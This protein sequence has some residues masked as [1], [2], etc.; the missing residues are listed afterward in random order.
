MSYLSVHIKH[1]CHLSSKEPAVV[2]DF[3]WVGLFLNWMSIALLGT[4]L[5]VLP[6][7]SNIAV[8][9]RTFDGAN[10]SYVGIVATLLILAT[11]VG[12]VV[13]LKALHKQ[14]GKADA[15]SEGTPNHTQLEP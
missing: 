14:L 1:L 9:M 11:E 4:T 3:P 10:V 7:L 13:A 15:S 12:M 6:L 8:V 2:R 5:F